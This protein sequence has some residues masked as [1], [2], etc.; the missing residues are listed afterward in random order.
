MESLIFSLDI[1]CKYGI[2]WIYG[3]KANQIKMLLSWANYLLNNRSILKIFNVP[4][5]NTPKNHKKIRHNPQSTN[6][7]TIN[8]PCLKETHFSVKSYNAAT[9]A[10]LSS[11]TIN[12]T[13]NSGRFLEFLKR[14]QNLRLSSN[15]ATPLGEA[16]LFNPNCTIFHRWTADRERRAHPEGPS[17]RM[18]TKKMD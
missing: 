5:N 3:V 2:N 6:E 12:D 8:S 1:D 10:H 7:R 16:V 14:T 13:F 18:E 17:A 15:L 9:M 4:Y 11:T